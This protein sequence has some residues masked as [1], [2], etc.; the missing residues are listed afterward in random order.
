VC[1]NDRPAGW[2]SWLRARVVVEITGLSRATVYRHA[3]ALGGRRVGRA[4]R[5]DPSVIAAYER[6][7]DRPQETR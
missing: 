4:V 5:F 7:V 1:D 3:T 6:P 2:K